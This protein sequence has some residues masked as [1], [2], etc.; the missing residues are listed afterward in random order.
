LEIPALSTLSPINNNNVL[1]IIIIDSKN[2]VLKFFLIPLP[3]YAQGFPSPEEPNTKYYVVV[4]HF[5]DG[6]NVLSYNCA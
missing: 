5:R 6:R 4:Y 2:Q 3:R 1:L